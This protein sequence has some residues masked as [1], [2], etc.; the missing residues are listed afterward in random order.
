MRKLLS[1]S[2]VAG[3]SAV[4]TIGLGSAA[5]LADPTFTVTNPSTD[6]RFTASGTST[7]RDVT[8][9]Q[10][11]VCST[12]SAVGAAPSGTGLPGAAIATITDAAFGTTDDPCRGNLG[13]TMIGVQH[14]GSVWHLN[15]VSVDPDGTV[16]LTITGIDVDTVV[17]SILGHCTTEVRGEAD[18]VTYDPSTGR[19]AISADPVPHLTIV[20]AAGG[21]SCAGLIKEGDQE[22]FTATY[23][24]SPRI[25]I[26]SP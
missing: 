12:T 1:S 20:T 7:T 21:T 10:P 22:T 24:V 17:S 15:V 19:L 8:T 11:S 25:Q 13:S 5:A 26:T 18:T 23:T 3:V 14:P 9:N 16:N 4:A 2:L 6:G